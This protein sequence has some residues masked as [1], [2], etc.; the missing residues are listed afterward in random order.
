MRID[1]AQL[2]V[3]EVEKLEKE[4]NILS[5]AEKIYSTVT[6]CYA[7]LYE[8]SESI[9]ERLKSVVKELQS[10]AKL[11]EALQKIFDVC[12]QSHYQIEDAAFSLGKYRDGFN[13]DPQRLEY[14]EE[15]LNS[16]RKLKAKYGST[17]EDILSY[18]DETEL[19]LKQLTGEGTTA[20]QVD[21]EITG[22]DRGIETERQSINPE[23]SFNG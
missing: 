6:S 8:S 20:E 10:V 15:R 3:G 9:V 23:T 17:V 5:N 2:K 14:I 19:K 12:S 21:V 13:Y 18:R 4:R 22:I 11:D 1:K 16:I 7:Q